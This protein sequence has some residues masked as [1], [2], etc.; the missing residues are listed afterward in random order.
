MLAFFLFLLIPAA[1]AALGGLRWLWVEAEEK[2]MAED[3]SIALARAELED[4]RA[5]EDEVA[6]RIA[7]RIERYDREA[8]RMAAR[9]PT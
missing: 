9:R 6:R 8:K 1:A 4:R 2:R 3:I 5:R 7:E